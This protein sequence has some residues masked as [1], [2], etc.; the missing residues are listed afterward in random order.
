MDAGLRVGE[1]TFSRQLTTCWAEARQSH[2]C[3]GLYPVDGIA[4]GGSAC[5][6]DASRPVVEASTRS[7]ADRFVG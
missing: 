1:V 2:P 7:S 4:T 3:T 5:S 6:K